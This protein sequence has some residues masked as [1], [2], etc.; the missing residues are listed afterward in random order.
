MKEYLGVIVDATSMLISL[1][2]DKIQKIKQQCLILQENNNLTVLELTRLIRTFSSTIQ[3]VL[4]A[5]LEY[6]YLQ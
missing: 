1:P 4:L 3:A 6:R 2:K 5:L